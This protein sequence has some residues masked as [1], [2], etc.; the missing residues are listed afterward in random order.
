MSFKE[1][2]EASD[3]EYYEVPYRYFEFFEAWNYLKRFRQI[4]GMAISPLSF[5]DCLLYSDRLGVPGMYSLRFC[6]AVIT[7]DRAWITA[8]QEDK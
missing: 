1:F 6:D 8:Q 3:H 4:N 2:L 7:I 5:Q